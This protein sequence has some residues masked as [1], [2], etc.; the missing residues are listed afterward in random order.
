[1]ATLL[2]ATLQAEASAQA[3]ALVQAEAPAQAEAGSGAASQASGDA[4]G[5]RFAILASGFAPPGSEAAALLA[6]AGSLRLHSLH[7]FGCGSGAKAALAQAGA[8]AEG[9]GASLAAVPPHEGAEAAGDRQ[10][11]PRGCHCHAFHTC[12]TQHPL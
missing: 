3:E 4:F 6:A 10:V 11:K 5:L 7:V 12:R 1:M 9:G 2:L 8:A